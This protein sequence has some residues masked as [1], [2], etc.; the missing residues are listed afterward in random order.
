MKEKPILF[1]SPMVRA[2]LEGRKSQTR[3]IVKFPENFDGRAVYDNHPFG[4]KYSAQDETVYRLFPKWNDGDILWVRETFA[5][6]G[7]NFHDDWPGHG[8]FYYKA[9]DPFSELEPGSPTKGIFRWRPSIF[10]P[11]EACRIRLEVTDV[12]VERLD[13]ISEEDA[14][15]EGI[16]L[17]GDGWKS[18]EI[19]HAGRHK[20]EPNPH[21]FV[22]NK[23]PITSYMELWEAIN[24]FDS[25]NK[26]P[27]VWVIEFKRY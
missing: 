27:W 1:S 13:T 8:E 18:Y 23:S 5:R 25:W 20:G 2:I 24:G 12:R 14:I 9:D 22:P 4:L 17:E 16:E 19:I 15:A 7:D 21:S 26:A 3:R 11:R 6:T 10:M